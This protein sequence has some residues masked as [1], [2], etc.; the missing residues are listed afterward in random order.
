MSRRNVLLCFDAFG[1]LFY[2]KPS[3]P[4]QYASVARQ[5]GLV[6]VT[7]EQVKKS[8]KVAYSAAE[9]AHP[10]YGKSTGMGAEKWW[11]DVI[12]ETFQLITGSPSEDLPKDLAPRLLQRFTSSD[13]YAMAPSVATLLRS[14]KEQQHRNQRSGP[15]RILVGVITNS[16]DRVPSVLSSFGLRV[17]PA[18][19]GTHFDPTELAQ[20]QQSQPYDVDLHCM[21]YDV[22]VGKPDRRIFDAAVRMADELATS[23][24][25]VKSAVAEGDADPGHSSWLKIYVGDEYVKDVVG[26]RE[27]GWYPVYVGPED[28][29][30][31]QERF[32]SLKQLTHATTFD[33]AFSKNTSRATIRAHSVQEFLEWLLERCTF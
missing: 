27:A 16:D 19:F 20:R 31:D 28:E 14:I 32:V 1:T 8:I 5:C 4:E 30:P 10:N 23:A 21:S 25:L 12:Q 3:V 2:P 29:L 6:S 15:P 22:G 7:A 18:R 11:T 13:G 33:E 24:A 17:S 9:K 26:S